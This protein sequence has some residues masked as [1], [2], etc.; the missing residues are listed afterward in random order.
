MSL[1]LGTALLAVLASPALIERTDPEFP[2]TLRAAGVLEGTA[3]VRLSIDPLGRVER[4]DLLSADD[5]AFFRALC[6]V[7]H[8][9]RFEPA[10][11]EGERVP[12]VADLTWRFR[13]APPATDGRL[14]GRLMRRGV[15][16]PLA[17]LVIRI[18]DIDLEG[19]SDADGRFEL[20]LPAGRH[21]VV[22][23]D[24]QVQRFTAE[25]EIAAG[26]TLAIEY[27]LTPVVGV[28][29]DL[30][31]V[32]RAPPPELQRTRL[33]TFELTHVAGTMGD[34]LRV[35]QSLP[36]VG[37]PM[38][39][40]PYPVVR[41]APP[42]DSAYQVDGAPVPL[43]YHLG[44][45]TSV[46]HPRLIDRVDFY[47]GVAPIE[48]GRYVGGVVDA[49]TRKPEAKDWLADLDVNLFQS[50]A[51]ISAPVGDTTRLT[52]GGRYSYTGLLLTVFAPDVTID[53]WDY[54]ARID[55]DLPDDSRLQITA[56]GARDVF[57]AETEDELTRALFHRLTTRFT[58]PVGE[59]RLL[60]GLDVGFDEVEAD[61]E[62]GDAVS[63]D[64]R[65]RLREYLVRPR[66]SWQHPLAEGLALQVGGDLEI[67]ESDDEIEDEPGGD[68]D[69]IR[70]FVG[71]NE[72]RITGGTFASLQ[73]QATEALTLSPGLRVDVY[74]RDEA[75][76][77]GSTG[78]F[79]PGDEEPPTEGTTQYQ[80]TADPRIAARYRVAQE[81][82]LKGHF[83]LSHA[84]QRFF[85]P[86]PGLGEVE[87]DADPIS[88]WQVAAGLEH[89]FDDRWSLDVT[90]Y[91]TWFENLLGF[92]FSEEDEVV[93]D[94]A[95]GEDLTT[96]DFTFGASGRGAG[97]EVMLRRRRAGSWFGWLAVT[98]QRQEREQSD[99]TW[100]LSALDQTLLVNVVATWQFADLWSLGGR[101]HYHTGRPVDVE[102]E[103]RVPGFAQLDVRLD[104]T[105]IHDTW[106][107]DLYLDVINASYQEEI[108]E[109]DE[110]GD[111][112]G[113]RYILPTLG[114]HAVF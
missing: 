5:P 91:G 76:S 8:T 18:Q 11:V 104:K 67:R 64:E 62:D 113:I 111:Q 95:E 109:V 36:G 14:T 41:G 2:P 100:A 32:G 79:F 19:F 68:D 82:V 69:S 4:M 80:F 56:F 105:W 61:Q 90:A 15:R 46:L 31:V 6:A 57:G 35:L 37:T 88:A 9:W 93:S 51:L 78:L 38:S 84:P 33:D 3:T 108:V 27:D 48:Y 107:I 30:V 86:I 43:L 60:A 97:V 25:V 1:P 99:G 40:L 12:A 63:E 23:E 94:Q 49:A 50:G 101:L 10:V 102:T 39:L 58:T 45:G 20:P 34:P 96:D 106:Q 89:A 26:Q 85:V 92:D 22:I 24:P 47:P 114:V 70:S 71:V 81:T 55:Q 98:L 54:Q 13:S 66:V 74:R 52:L 7:M 77:E 42:G 72:T 83:G 21:R 28:G 16:A 73:W 110:E 59:G 75:D 103:Q 17:G 65:S 112:E 44:V 87:V 53:F 29:A